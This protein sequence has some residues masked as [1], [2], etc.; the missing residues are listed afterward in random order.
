MPSSRARSVVVFLI[1]VGG[2]DGPRRLGCSTA[3]LELCGGTG[4]PVGLPARRSLGAA[5]SS[6]GP[7]GAAMGCDPGAVRVVLLVVAMPVTPLAVCMASTVPHGRGPIR[8]PQVDLAWTN[9]WTNPWT[10]NLSR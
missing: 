1:E 4:G 10:I 7:L 8:G 2:V 3:D 6:P 5:E 9:P